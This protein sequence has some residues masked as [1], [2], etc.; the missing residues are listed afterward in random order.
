MIGLFRLFL[1]AVKT[2]YLF[3]KLFEILVFEKYLFAD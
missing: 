1:G 2:F 3:L